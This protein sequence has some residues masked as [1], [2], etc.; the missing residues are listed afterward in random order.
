MKQDSIILIV[1]DKQAG[2]DT[3]EALLFS[4]GHNLAFA[5]DGPEALAKAGEL[6]P[7]LILLDVM[8]PGMD[9]F[10][11]CRRLRSDQLLAEVPIIMVTA[12]DDRESRLQG[13]EAGA[14]D[15]VSKPFDRTELRARVRTII[16][17][18]RY[19]RLL[20]MNQQ[21]ENKIAQLSALYEISSALIDTDVLLKSVVQ[22][23]RGLLDVE[24]VSILLWDQENDELRFPVVAVEEEGIED[25]L[26]QTHVPIDSGIAGWVF[27]E[28]RPALVQ[29][30]SMDE[31]FYEGIDRIAGFTTRSILCVP[32]RGKENILGVL[33]AVN[34]K[35]GEFT[36]DD[37]YLL[38]AMADNIAI[39]I[40]KANLYR[41]VQE[42]EAVTRHQNAELK[43]TV[44]ALQ[45]A[46]KALQTEITERRRMEGSLREALAKLEEMQQK[47]IQFEKMAALGRFSSGIAHEVK[48]PLAI[49]L[50]GMEF[51][52]TRLPDVDTDAKLA[53]EKI[54]AAALRADNVLRNLLKFAKPSK[55]ELKTVRANDLINETLS[56][57]KYK[58][59]LRRIEIETLFPEED[60]H[61]EVDSLQIQQV[62][63]NIL[64]NSVEAMPNGGQIKIRI[65][66]ATSDEGQ[67]CCVTEVI[68]TGEGIS[69]DA[70]P[71]LLKPFF[72][73]KR[74]GK[75]TGLGLY[76]SK[77]ILANHGG[78]LL[79]DSKPG[80]GTNVKVILPLR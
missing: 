68:D 24:G 12:L 14:D 20:T 54:E 17:L 11:V 10:E 75:G 37:Q 58:T 2:R 3:L 19:R 71:K 21:L 73:T 28:G 80:E 36:K 9:G 65:Y 42:A 49:I 32:L 59:S 62:L 45:M 60:I 6:T 70:L 41:K 79:I 53:M 48:N 74:N 31:R 34:K 15:F 61:L 27:R 52:K 25:R 29:D 43:E 1:D 7:D 55:L 72:T 5:C 78:D 69:E 4:E 64:L 63:F 23:A 67:P 77:M 44:E 57:F 13:I 39:S 56:F 26:E 50:S 16:R 47:L 66:R 40:E 8:M 18:N 46:V 35:R 33:E 76:I 22:K 38:E 51:L 30:V